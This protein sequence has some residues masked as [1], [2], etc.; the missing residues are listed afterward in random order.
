MKV[1]SEIANLI[2]LLPVFKPRRTGI[3]ITTV[4]AL[5]NFSRP[6][7]WWRLGAT[8]L[9]SSN[10]YI[11]PALVWLSPGSPLFGAASTSTH[12]TQGG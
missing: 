11:N 2:V 6:P 12:F 10:S 5:L 3:I 1:L 9:D 4:S 8:E 7:G